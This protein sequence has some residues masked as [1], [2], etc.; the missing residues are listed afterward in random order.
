MSG[1]HAAWNRPRKVFGIYAGWRGRLIDAGQL[2]DLTFWNRKD[3]A[4]RV[5]L[6]SIRELLGRARAFRDT[7]D[8]TTWTGSLLP[9]GAAPATGEMLRSTRLLTIGHSFGGLIVYAAIAQYF[10]D[11]AAASATAQSLGATANEDKLI[12][13]YGDLVVIVNPGRGGGQLGADPP[14][15]PG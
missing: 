15:R 11:R 1:A 4:Q 8:R 13:S 3:A 12:P 10:V 6:G 14:N 2:S 5:A 7:I 9:A